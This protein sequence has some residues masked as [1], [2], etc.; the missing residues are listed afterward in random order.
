MP[1]A[2]DSLLADV[3]VLDLTQAVAGPYC[4]KLLAD[5]GAEVIKMERPGVGDVSRRMG[6]FPGDLPHPEKSGLF[7]SLNTNK[8]S[9]TLDLRSATGQRVLRDL[10]PQADILLESYRPGVMARWGLGYDE[11]RRLNPRIVMTS[12]SSF[13]QWGPYRDYAMTELV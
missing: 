3:T 9:V 2:M 10:I 7:L 8:K 1:K 11:V 6:P 12:V 5:Y 13:G 4:S